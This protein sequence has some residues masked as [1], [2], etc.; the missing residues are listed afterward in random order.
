MEEPILGAATGTQML[1]ENSLFMRV[2]W[3]RAS[4]TIE[5]SVTYHEVITGR[6]RL[7]GHYVCDQ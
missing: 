4:R 2:V 5:L 1:R 7:G 6:F 3:P